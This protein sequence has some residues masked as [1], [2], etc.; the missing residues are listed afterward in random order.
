Y[1]LCPECQTEL[2]V[3]DE[4]E[5]SKLHHRYGPLAEDDIDDYVM[6]SVVTKIPNYELHTPEPRV[7]KICVEVVP[8]LATFDSRHSIREV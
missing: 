8:C 6:C 2:I 5:I 1:R 3:C 7:K 4:N